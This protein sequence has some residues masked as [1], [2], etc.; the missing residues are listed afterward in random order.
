M[1]YA[2][3]TAD[4]WYYNSLSPARGYPFPEVNTRNMNKKIS[5]WKVTG[6]DDV[7]R[8]CIFLKTVH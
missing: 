4:E 8:F 1:E 3:T 5:N 2:K 6:F 7:Q